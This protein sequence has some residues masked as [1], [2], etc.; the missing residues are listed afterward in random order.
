M[1]LLIMVP[2]VYVEWGRIGK[3]SSHEQETHAE[4]ES[5]KRL[6]ESGL[7]HRG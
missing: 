2:V 3:A 5:S 1:S 7:P 6:C 4:H